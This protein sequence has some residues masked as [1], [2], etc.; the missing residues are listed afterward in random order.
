MT[1]FVVGVFWA[2]N[3]PFLLAQG[4]SE[5]MP[6]PPTKTGLNIN[7]SIDSTALQID[8]TSNRYP[9][10]SYDS[11]GFLGPTLIWN[12]GDSLNITV[13]NNLSKKSTVHWHGAHVPANMDGGPHSQIDPGTMWLVDGVNPHFKVFDEPA[14]MWYH[15][16]AHGSTLS[17]VQMGLA[18][19]IIVQDTVGDPNYA[20]LPHTY[21]TDDIP[22][23]LSDRRFPT[24]STFNSVLGTCVIGDTV[25]VN[26]K[27]E[28]FQTVPAQRVRFRVLNG[29]SNRTY[30]V[31]VSADSSGT[32]MTPFEMIAT[33]AGYIENKLSLDSIMLT[34]GERAEFVI[35]FTGDPIGTEYYL[36]NKAGDLPLS[37][38]GG[39]GVDAYDPACYFPP[40]VFPG[41][42]SSYDSIT[43]P[44]L[45]LVVGPPVGTPAGAVPTALTVITKPTPTPGS[46]PR[47][48]EF[49]DELS[50]PLW[51]E[52]EPFSIDHIPMDMTV[53]NE[54]IQLNE[55]LE[56]TVVNNTD[57]AHP[58]HIHHN[59]FY[60][61][62]Y[63]NSTTIPPQL[64]GPKDVVLIQGGDSLKFVMEFTS[65]PTA[66]DPSQTYMY[67]CHILTHED[68][69]MMHQFVITDTLLGTGR[70]DAIA[71]PW[72]VYPNPTTGNLFVEGAC[73]SPSTIQL[74]D[75]KG[76]IVREIHVPPFNGK[77]GFDAGEVPNGLYLLAWKRP[78]G[79][80]SKRILIE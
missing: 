68:G 26:G 12:K 67:H 76:A 66:I 21:G 59:H 48:K 31:G 40:D 33:D 80:L 75:S 47:R 57:V 61:T 79:T 65:F 69:G 3:C 34:N 53:I 14:T 45:K 50:N 9:S 72:K 19:M 2:L 63:N 73:D 28:P 22:V 10:F 20:L 4:W 13:M 39:P 35:D 15:P 52:P 30:L 77:H 25:L 32:S 42:I 36:V 62:E 17:Q 16:H 11:L 18:G 41:T 43:S 58:W 38:P 5:P 74:M 71:I 24:D 78:E 46:L 44:L 8:T 6:I 23:V 70:A 55:V 37:V 51:L 56:W 29:S 54:V 7:L 49:H 1:C 64:D 60:L 27:L